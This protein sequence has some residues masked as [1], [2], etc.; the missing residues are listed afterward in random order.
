MHPQVPSKPQEPKPKEEGLSTAGS[1]GLGGGFGDASRTP[2]VALRS[3][4][5]EIST[6]QK[7]KAASVS[8]NKAA[9]PRPEGDVAAPDLPTIPPSQNRNRQAHPVGRTSSTGNA[10]IKPNRSVQTQ[11]L[12]KGYRKQ[13][14][15]VPGRLGSALEEGDRAYRAGQWRQAAAAY[16]RVSAP[17]A[18]TLHKLGLSYLRMGQRHEARSAF[19]AALRR[20]PRFTPARQALKEMK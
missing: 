9:A 10:P 15:D 3:T 2:E 4:V 6:V 14:Q 13:E 5:D 16:R 17:N 11:P 8:K 12:S 18:E 1:G 19:Q 7:Q 20:N